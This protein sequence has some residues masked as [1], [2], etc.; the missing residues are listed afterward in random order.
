VQT[1]DQ[2][3]VYPER[4]FSPCEDNGNGGIFADFGYDFVVSHQGACF[5]L[6]VAKAA[7]QVAS[8]K[9]DEDCRS[10]CVVAFTL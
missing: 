8:G 6:C 10:T 1:V 4:R 7:F 5:V 3:V 9:T 2:C